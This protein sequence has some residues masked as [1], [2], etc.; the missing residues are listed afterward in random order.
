VVLLSGPVAG[1]GSRAVVHVDLDGARHIYRVHGWRYPAAD[2]PLFETGLTGALELFAREN[3]T[4][5]FFVIAEDLD[6]PAKRPLLEAIVQR[7]HEVGSHSVTHCRLTSLSP[8]E[9]HREIYH[10]RAKLEDALGIP[11]RGFR[12]PA[13]D[14]DGSIIELVAGAGYDYDSSL[15]GGH[16]SSQRK[17]GR[18]VPT[19]PFTIE[20]RSG[21]V[22][23][24]LP[25]P[26]GFPTPFHPSYSL[27]FGTWYFRAGLT[28][29]R[30]TVPTFVLLFHLT[31]FAAPLEGAYLGPLGSRLFTLS[32]L[33]ASTKVARCA[34]MLAAVRDAYAIVPTTSLLESG[35]RVST[36]GPRS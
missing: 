14:L 11:V 5:T 9:R 33:K 27:L 7:G 20:P 3:V 13:L 22:E 2:D 15:F 6:D 24:P 12:A 16:P 32:H 28:K 1:S 17:L 19:G 18:A 8:A 23:L 35:G 29:S 26:S 4:A 30:A 36:T 25:R 21:L 31:D 34:E 10:S